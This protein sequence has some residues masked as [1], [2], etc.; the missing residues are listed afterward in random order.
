MARLG[1][2]LHKAQLVWDELDHGV[3]DGVVGTEFGDVRLQSGFVEWELGDS[4]GPHDGGWEG[5]G[6]RAEDPCFEVLLF[7]GSVGV[8]GVGRHGWRRLRVVVVVLTKSKERTRL[9][10]LGVSCHG[11]W[12]WSWV[13]VGVVGVVVRV[14][15]QRQRRVWRLIECPQ[16]TNC[17][18]SLQIQLLG[19]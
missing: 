16:V 11:G 17:L 4:V 7:R 8:V 14:S 15:K 19:V 10:L 12:R 18:R 13:V 3:D 2:L 9:C 5:V 6:V 1:V